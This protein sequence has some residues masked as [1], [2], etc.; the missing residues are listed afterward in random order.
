M[1][2][3]SPSVGEYLP[4]LV[5]GTSWN[6]CFDFE[7]VAGRHAVL[8][9]TGS[10]SHP[11]LARVCAD[12]R[13]R[14]APFDDHRASVFIVTN[15]PADI[16]S[17]RLTDRIPGLRIF[18][19]FRAEIAG[20]CGVARNGVVTAGS[21]ILDPMLRVLSW[22]PVLDPACHVDEVAARIA[23]QP[24]ILGMGQ[25]AAP[26]PPPILVVPNIFDPALCR[27]LI[28]YYDQRGGEDSG[29]MRSVG[30]RILGVRDYS[31]KRRSDRLVEDG[32]LRAAVRQG[33]VRRLVPIIK[34]AFQFEA[35]HLERYM[36]ACYDSA[37]GGYFLPHT[38]NGTPA[39]AH[40][41][42]AVSIHLNSGDYDGGEVRFPEFGMQSYRAPTGG[43]AVFS[44]SL[45]HEVTPVTRGRRLIF[46]TF[47]YG[48]AD[49]ELRE[50]NAGHCAP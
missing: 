3:V 7:T 48:P 19:D 1:G 17:R 39:T 2:R 47:V 14:R 38:D 5:A 45:L 37:V 35:T 21:L 8:F 36:V 32:A 29:V 13:A 15:D 27:R 30:G 10:A 33:I 24:P 25:T 43:A 22:C 46:L 9:F 50:R 23:A 6:P 40:R 16:A 20:L 4:K 11:G 28:D 41:R 26:V 42:F 18:H 12:Y 34:R 49:A 44:V 31:L